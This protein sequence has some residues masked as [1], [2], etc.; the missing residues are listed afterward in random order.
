MGLTDDQRDDALKALR[1]AQETLEY[2]IKGVR[3][4]EEAA[5]LRERIDEI[6]LYLKRAK[7]ALKFI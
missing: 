4:V 7:M 5:T 6:E 2:L 1:G 3:G